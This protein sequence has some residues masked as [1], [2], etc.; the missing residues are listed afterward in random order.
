[1][2]CAALI[3]AGL[4]GTAFTIRVNC[5]LSPLQLPGWT[6]LAALNDLSL[7]AARR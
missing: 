3:T 5:R 6:S 7:F 4:F 2:V 1:M